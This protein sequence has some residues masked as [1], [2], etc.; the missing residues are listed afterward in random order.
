VAGPRS[1]LFA[2]GD[3]HLRI[4]RVMLAS[5]HGERIAAYR[6]V[7]REVALEHLAR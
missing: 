4:R 5:F 7:T 6:A 2:D 1:I 3:E